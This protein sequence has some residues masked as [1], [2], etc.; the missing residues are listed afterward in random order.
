MFYKIRCIFYLKLLILVFLCLPGNY[1][2]AANDSAYYAPELNVQI[3]G[4]VF[5]ENPILIEGDYITIPFLATY[6]YAF[7]KYSVGIALIVAAIMLIYGGYLYL[8]S[9][10]G[11]QVQNAK[12][13]MTDAIVGMVIFLGA[14]VIIANINPNLLQFSGL[15]MLKVQQDLWGETYPDSSIEEMMGVS[16]GSG[17]ASTLT[18]PTPMEGEDRGMNKGC[19][20]NPVYKTAK[21]ICNSVESCKCNSGGM[22]DF[23]SSIYPKLT[24]LANFNEISSKT[25]E[26]QIMQHGLY[27]P[28]EGGGAFLIPDAK[29]ALI[30][31]G[32]IAKKQGYFLYVPVTTRPVESHV[33]SW[34]QRMKT[35][36]KTQGLTAPGSSAHNLGIAIDVNLGTLSD[37][38][39][40]MTT[41][42]VGKKGNKKYLVVDGKF[43]NTLT[44]GGPLCGTQ[45]NQVDGTVAL[46]IENSRILQ[47]IL[48]EA[49]WRRTCSEMWHYNYSGVYSID[50]TECAFPPTPVH[51]EMKKC[52]VKYK[53]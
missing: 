24:D 18:S 22:P 43:A 31:A 50:C 4:L 10:T 47:K 42:Q 12:Q 9:S 17:K 21:A 2:D 34:C 25:P 11:V 20:V 19:V 32:E 27:F 3:P 7:F 37:K 41:L 36:G 13:K 5:T 35:E 52:E 28:K 46:G 45:T 26:E 14:Y 44:V 8:L 6:I 51:S 30:R 1:A 39:S 40:P 29:N 33:Q 38:K 16:T 49:G 53:P 48:A 15:S 23:D